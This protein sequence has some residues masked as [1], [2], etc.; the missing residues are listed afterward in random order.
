MKKFWNEAR[1]SD[2]ILGGLL[3]LVIISWSAITIHANVTNGHAVTEPE[4]LQIETVQAP[5]LI[6]A[7]QAREIAVDLVG[8]GYVDE[9]SLDT[10]EEKT[11]FLIVINYDDQVFQVTLDAANGELVHLDSLTTPSSETINLSGNLTSEDAIEIA[12][13]HLESIGI[14]SA[15]LAYSYSDIEDGIAVWSIEFRYN[16]RDLEFYV[17]KETGAFLKAPTA[18]NTN[19]GQTGSTSTPAPTPTPTPVT[20]ETT[21]TISREEAGQIALGVTPGRLAEVSRDRENGRPAWWVEVRHE[22]MVHEFYIDMATGA[23]LQHEV[24]IDD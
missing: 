17:V 22:G 21:E 11:T 24:E 16:G 18:L 23:I 1:L 12:R 3:A 15:T 13:Q 6:T 7:V 9:L 4:T 20:S 5:E 19:S 14:T 8:G 10:T 2:K